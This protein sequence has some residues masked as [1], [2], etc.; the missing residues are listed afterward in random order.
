MPERPARRRAAARRRRIGFAAGLVVGVVAVGGG[1]AWAVNDNSG[2]RYRVATAALGSVVQKVTSAG[3]VS[4]VNQATVA[5]PISGKVSAVGVRLGDRVTAGQTLA[6]LDSTTLQQ[7]VASARSVV[8][9]ATQTLANDQAAQAAGTATAALVAPDSA[10]QRV[11]L[12]SVVDATPGRS[13]AANTCQAAIAAVSRAQRQVADAQDAQAADVTALDDAVAALG[14][15]TTTLITAVARLNADLDTLSTA[16]TRFEAQPTSA[17]ALGALQTAQDVVTKQQATVQAAQAD[18]ARAQTAAGTA[19]HAVAADQAQVPGLIAAAGRAIA[20]E[21]TTCASAGTGGGSPKTSGSPKPTAAPTATPSAS[22]R[23][24]GDSAR[25][26][27]ST[28]APSS[29]NTSGNRSSG[30][31]QPTR[32][33]TVVQLAADQAQIN[34]ATAELAVAEQNLD[35]TRLTSPITGTVAAVGL[36][37]GSNADGSITIIGPGANEVSTT[38]TLTNIDRVKVGQPAS[39]TV[40]GVPVAVTGRV[41]SIGLLNTTSGSSTAYP[42]KVLLDPTTAR[43]YDGSGATVVITTAAVHN[44]LTVPSSGVRRLASVSTVQVLR[45]GKVTTARVTVG[46]VGSD[47]TQIVAGLNAGDQIVLATVSEPLPTGD[48]TN[49]L[50]IGTGSSLT[51]GGGLTGGAVTGGRQRGG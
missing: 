29:S 10:G 4:S 46:A 13:A 23:S 27:P 45:A 40:D 34:A 12:L 15:A 14:R 9:Q 17:D 37:T 33:I 1:V 36:S 41:I 11:V 51:G 2:P 20:R 26:Q 31:S 8:A 42:L 22:A 39:V 3:A 30:T 7:A 16:I 32:T 21:T 50:R 24:G 48:I 18:L 38:V 43:L 44:V 49:R 5:F 19:S 6:A 35:Q 47:L 28:A 25:S